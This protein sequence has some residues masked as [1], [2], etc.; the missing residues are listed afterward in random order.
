MK[1]FG[2]YVLEVSDKKK[3]ELS[4]L[5]QVA[6]TDGKICSKLD[7]APFMHEIADKQQRGK[8]RAR[9]TSDLESLRQHH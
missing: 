6:G 1:L 3:Q 9:G 5:R 7:I 4:D 2:T 8:A